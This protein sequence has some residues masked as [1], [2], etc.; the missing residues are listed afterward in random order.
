[1]GATGD[2]TG[3]GWA[4][5]LETFDAGASSSDWVADAF[6]VV[7]ALVSTSSVSRMLGRGGGSRGVT[8]EFLDSGSTFFGSSGSMVGVCVGVALSFVS[9]GPRLSV[10]SGSC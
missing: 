7:S 2:G 6:G 9:E 5:L 8:V 10:S 1:M 3:A 4:S